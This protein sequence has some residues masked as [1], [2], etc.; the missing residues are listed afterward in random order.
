MG[1]MLAAEEMRP[2]FMKNL[3]LTLASCVLGVAATKRLGRVQLASVFLFGI[4]T[5][6][7]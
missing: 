3:K 6:Y 5:A 2:E 4:Y 7:R 1:F